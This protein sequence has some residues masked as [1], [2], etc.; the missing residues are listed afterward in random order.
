[1][2]WT[3]RADTEPC[4]PGEQGAV[5]ATEKVA[6]LL[7][8]KM[9]PKE[10]NPLKRSEVFRDKNSTLNN[11]CGEASGSSVVRCGSLTDDA[12]RERAAI[13]AARRD[14]RKPNG[15]W[16][17]EVGSLRKIRLKNGPDEQIIFV[18]DDPT[19]NDALH[20]VIRGRDMPQ[21]QHAEIMDCLEEAFA[22]R[23]E[24]G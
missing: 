14:G 2:G 21:T 9:V 1:M 3:H 20:A 13:Q 12:L 18:Y 6:R 10:H 5:G 11:V 8:S 16:V 24:P 4:C 15:A 22:G 17:A 7:H 23:V 19:P